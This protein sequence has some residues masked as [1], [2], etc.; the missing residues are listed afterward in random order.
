LG[1]NKKSSNNFLGL[2]PKLSSLSGAKFVVI[3]APYEATASYGKGTSRGPA[4]ILRASRHV[5]TFDEDLVSEPCDAGIHT[6]PPL[7]LKGLGA[8]E[9]QRRIHDSVSR[10]VS[11]R[12]IPAMLGGEHSITPAAV[13]ACKQRFKDISVLQI[14]AHADLRERYTG[15]RYSHASAMR[16]VLDICPLVQ[17][18]IRNIS[19]DEYVFAKRSGQ[20]KRMHFMHGLT[21]KSFGRIVGQL[22]KHVYVTMDVDGLDPSVI[23]ATGTPEPGGLSWQQ[24][25]SL[26]KRVARA[27]K[28]VGFD[29]VELSPIKGLAMADF[30]AAKLVYKMMGF[31]SQRS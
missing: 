26:L 10:V 18:G 21:G 14:D 15:T 22:K 31:I 1:G 6:L 30:A 16:R 27:K 28:V 7:R 24:A 4:A 9:V 12:K 29:L 13:S 20:L 17:V 25:L 8:R 2:E 19:E 5:E 11:S 23:P 3:P